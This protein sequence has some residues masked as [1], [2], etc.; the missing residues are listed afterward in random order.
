MLA[1][2]TN[3]INVYTGRVHSRPVMD[4]ILELVREGRLRPQDVTGETASWDDAAE[5][6]ADHSSKLVISR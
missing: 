2:Y 5:A 1:M 4:P 3:G 6:M